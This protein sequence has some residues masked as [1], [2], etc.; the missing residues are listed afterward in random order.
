MNSSPGARTAPDGVAER[1]A[2][3]KAARGRSPIGG[4]AHF[5]R[6]PGATGPLE[7]LAAQE[8]DRVASLLPIRRGRMLATP[9]S[10]YRGGAAIMAADL[11]TTPTSGLLA[12]TCG[13]A[14]LSNFGVYRSSDRR[15]VF[16]L[17]DFDETIPGPWE[18]D[19]KRLAASLCVAGRDR[20]FTLAQRL[21]IAT[22][23]GAAYR[24]AMRELAGLTNLAV[25]Y[26]RAEVDDWLVWERIAAP[27]RRRSRAEV[28]VTKTDRKAG[29]RA[30]KKLTHLVDGQRRLISK[31]PLLVPVEELAPEREAHELMETMARMLRGYGRSL[32][33]DRRALLEQFRLVHMARKV[34]GVGS[35]GTEAWVLL[36][37]GRDDGD[38]LLLQAKEAS[39]SVL[40]PY[41]RTVRFANQGR[42][43]VAGQH[44]M[45][46]TSD[47]FLGSQQVEAPAVRPR[48]FYL[49]Q[50]RDGKGSVA[51]GR[52]D[53]ADLVSYGRLCGW[54]LARAHARS[55]DRIAIAAYLG[56]STKFERAVAEFAETYADQNAADHRAL[57]A[58]VA[59]GQ[60]AA[61]PGV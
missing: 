6:P 39:A 52:M 38:P 8:A 11:A 40:A 1:A 10:F 2:R 61:E 57:A 26:A 44:L 42:R 49:R 34:V 21:T 36:L 24:T 59:S 3:G 43:V 18:W 32:Q 15:M 47:I 23:A 13:D 22:A 12:Q 48:D 27:A 53:P 25:W 16:D 28:L 14:H 54:T 31:P 58:A 45:Q 17:D 7:I 30:A 33:S 46:A 60:V 50:L 19:V 20:G 35:V 37:V 5:E 29:R 41:V 51:V 9:F 4:L 55:G 56:S